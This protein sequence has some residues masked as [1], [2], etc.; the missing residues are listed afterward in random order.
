MC[1]S[2]VVAF[3]IG[4]KI[5][6]FS[7]V[8]FSFHFPFSDILG[9]HLT[10]FQTL[11]IGFRLFRPPFVRHL[12]HQ[13]PISSPFGLL[14]YLNLDLS[15]GDLCLFYSSSAPPDFSI[16]FGKEQWK[17]PSWPAATWPMTQSPISVGQPWLLPYMDMNYN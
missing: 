12:C 14:Y 16:D 11:I 4:I 7:T 8:Q 5:I 2:L 17:P 13:L 9:Y 10:S 3:S 15:F 6:I 1:I